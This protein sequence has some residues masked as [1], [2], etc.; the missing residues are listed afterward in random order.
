MDSLEIEVK[1][2]IA[3]PEALRKRILSLGAVGKGRFFERNLCFED[4]NKGLRKAGA[5]LRL[6]KDA[7]TTLTYKEKPPVEDDQFKIYR[8][9]EVTVDDF[10]VMKR[11]LEA[12]GFHQERVYEK[13]RETFVVDGAVLCM[14]TLPF[15]EFL[16]IEGPGET[17]KMLAAKLD[18]K[19]SDRI[20]ADYLALFEMARRKSNLSFLDVTFENFKNV[21]ADFFDILGASF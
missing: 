19:W 4:E 2:H 5:L 11:I 18:M 16:E 1:F 12:V 8:E 15:G 7:E 3:D 10:R 21:P 6:R 9:L 20:L 14:D 13:W 17:I